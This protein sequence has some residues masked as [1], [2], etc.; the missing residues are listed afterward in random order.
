MVWGCVNAQGVGELHF[1]QNIMNAD[2]H[3]E[4]LNT[5]MMPSLK[6]LGRGKIF[7]HDNYPKHS[8]RVTSAVLKKKKVKVLDCPSMS[9]DLN[10]IEHLW[11]VLKSKFEQRKPWNIA[12][13]WDV[14]TTEW[15]NI[16]PSTCTNLVHSMPRRLA[17]VINNQG[18]HTKYWRNIDIKRS[19]I[20]WPL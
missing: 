12:E 13:L 19:F 14:I 15:K 2:M 17:A 1:I 20:P 18:S 5:K 3:W 11:N 8:A 9:P 16:E 4:I 6:R 7:Q 10:P